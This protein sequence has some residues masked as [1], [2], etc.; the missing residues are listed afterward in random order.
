MNLLY[1]IIIIF[2][3]SI[4][5]IFI[6]QKMRIPVIIGFL[7]TGV[8][9]GPH[10]AG[11]FT[12]LHDVEILAEIGVIL[13]LFSIGME[14]SLSNLLQI[15]RTVLLGGALQVTLTTGIV[16]AIALYFNEPLNK[17]V[18]YGFLV[19]LSST[20]IVLKLMQE[21]G[22][23]N[24]SHG[25]TALG[26]LI[27]QDIIAIPMILL[28]PLLSGTGAASTSAVFIF[29][30]K[31]AGMIILTLAGAKW[32]VPFLLFHITRTRSRELFILTI[33]VL[34]FGIAG[35]TY[36]MGLS[37]ALG[38]FLAGL[39]ISETDYSYEAMGN[40]LPF[41]EIFTSIFFISIG[42]LLDYSFAVKN[43]APVLLLVFSIIVLKVAAIT[44]T[45]IIIG[46]PL[47]VSLMS[48]LVLS[49]VGE[50]SFIVSKTAR[51]HSLLETGHYQ[52]FLS[53]S[54][55]TMLAAP[56]IIAAAQ[57][58]P[59]LLEKIKLPPFLSNGYYSLS[60]AGHH[61]KLDDHII[62]I[63][64]GV[65]GRNVARSS[66][67]AEIASIVVEMNPETVRREQSKGINIIYGDASSDEILHEADID[68]ARCIV[69]TI[70]DAATAQRIVVMA[71][72]M[73]PDITI[74]TR[75]RFVQEVESLY[76]LGADVVI[77][78]EF[79][80]SIEIFSRVLHTYNIPENDIHHIIDEI[81]CDGYSELRGA[82]A[83]SCSFTAEIKRASGLNVSSW[84][85]ENNSPAGG[86][87]LQ[88]LNIRKLH[89]VSVIAIERGGSLAAN[90]DSDDRIEA[91]D[92]IFLL[93][94][95]EEIE[96]VRPL[97]TAK[98]KR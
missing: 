83:P 58:I 52:Y 54:I 96:S 55:L 28:I 97:F 92:I 68:S 14:F 90:P 39:I 61:E 43:I 32:I 7:I 85:V 45:G 9:C 1:E 49:Q 88:E 42:M 36:Y 35:L 69:V 77:P 6:F 5:V 25:K 18:A 22:E 80:T 2:A 95:S 40:I 33:V 67:W 53:V 23:M 62:I 87:T 4:A 37:L 70:P 56:F 60:L 29:V 38:A 73:N 48:G 13:L 84:R 27:F 86:K 12:S 72:K 98:E 10:G 46:L 75:T 41:K 93:G 20:A 3:I 34:C 89:G 94:S 8:I 82:N 17:A 47:S 66:Q 26:I 74:I 31:T 51:T 64:Y 44:V 24:A 76:R 16:I 65:N 57:R 81:R 30:A 21:R 11:L 63:G 79:E 78:E 19:S 50:F 15:K 59:R 71:R 91:E